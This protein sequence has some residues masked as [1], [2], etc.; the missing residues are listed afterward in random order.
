VTIN[1]TGLLSSALPDAIRCPAGCGMT[2]ATIGRTADGDDPTVLLLR[3][4]GWQVVDGEWTC[5][6]D[7]PEHRKALPGAMGR[8][9]NPHCSNCGDTR[10]GV[11]GH[12]A[13]ECTWEATT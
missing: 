12:E 5:P 8:R 1:I 4:R 10:G 11:Y 9:A 3:D 2:M 7:L 6:E 13:Y